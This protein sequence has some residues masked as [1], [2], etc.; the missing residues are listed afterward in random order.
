MTDHDI[1]VAIEA[2]LVKYTGVKVDNVLR[3]Y[4]GRRVCLPPNNDYIIMTLT[5]SQRLDTPSAEWNADT[6]TVIQDREGI[7]QLDFFGK[8]AAVRANA[9]VDLSRSPILCDFL[10]PFN[11]Q[12]LYADDVSNTTGISP[13]KNYVERR[14]VQLHLNY[15]TDVSVEVDTFTAAELNIFETEL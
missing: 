13:E 9:V 14:T 10:Q 12:V 11:I 6:Y 1:Y 2:M 15:A 5:N 8:N 3:A 4:P 7:M